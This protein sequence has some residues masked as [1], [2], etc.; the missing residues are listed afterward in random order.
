MFCP[1][2]GQQ[3]PSEELRFCPRCG[4]SLRPHAALLAAG[5]NAA[6]D[7]GRA[8]APVQTAR[9]VSTRRAAKLLFFTFLLLPIFVLFCIVVDGPEPLLAPF[10][11]FLAGL[12]WLVYPRLFSDD[13]VPVSQRRSRRDLG[14]GA[15]MPALGPQP[16]VPAASF[17]QRQTNTAEI[18]QPTSVTENTTRL[19]DKEA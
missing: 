2:C 14:T 7:T 10:I 3:Q 17:G 13:S 15:D 18:V 19:L 6:G 12:G 1:Q 8:P 5:N 11:M 9:R 16:F 4:L